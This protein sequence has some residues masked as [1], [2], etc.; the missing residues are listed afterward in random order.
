MFGYVKPVL[1]KLD[2]E[3]K[4]LFKSYYCGLC[5]SLKREFGEA[6]RFA[7][8]YDMTFLSILLD[9]LYKKENEKVKSNCI[10]NPFNKKDVI[11]NNK[12]LNYS[13]SINISLVYHKILDDYNDDSSMTALLLEKF[14]KR[15]KSKL[16]SNY[17]EINSLISLNLKALYYLEENRN[18]YSLDEIS[19]PFSNIVGSILRYYPYELID[20]SEDL[21][22][23]LYNFGY[24]LGKWIYLIDAYDDLENDMKK[25][26]FNPISIL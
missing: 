7:L 11:I 9:A 19:H 18:F 17:E 4:K 6:S 8:N 20:D 15:Y 22:D 25:N 16:T 10:T 23:K 26:K 3:N 24:N 1:C 2:E 14:F 21:R 12:A 5:F 13:S